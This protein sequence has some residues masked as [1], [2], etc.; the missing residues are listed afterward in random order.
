MDADELLARRLQSRY[1]IELT[2]CNTSSKVNFWYIS[3][4]D[5]FVIRAL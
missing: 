3:T 5:D 1:D 4:Y 2:E